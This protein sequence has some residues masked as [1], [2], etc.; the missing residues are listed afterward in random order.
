MNTALTNS[1][2]VENL[3]GDLE[4]YSRLAEIA[5]TIPLIGKSDLL[6]NDGIRVYKSS[7]LRQ[8]S[9]LRPFLF[10]KSVEEI[11]KSTE[12]QKD[13]SGEQE[14]QAAPVET[15]EMLTVAEKKNEATDSSL[16]YP[17]FAV[18]SLT[19]S[20]TS[21]MDA[22]LLMS[23][24]YTPPLLPS[25]LPSLVHHLF[26]PE[27]ISWL[28]HSTARKYLSWRDRQLSAAVTDL[29]SSAD[30]A[31][32]SPLRRA[33]LLRLASEAEQRASVPGQMLIPRRSIS[34]QNSSSL[35]GRSFTSRLSQNINLHPTVLD[36]IPRQDRARWLLE[37]I[38]EEV[39]YGNIGVI[40][41]EDGRH[42]TSRE[43]SQLELNH[44]E[45]NN[46]QNLVHLSRRTGSSHISTSRKHSHRRIREHTELP[47]WA[48]QQ[49][50]GKVMD[51]SDPLG[52]CNAW[53]GWG[54]AIMWGAS[55]GIVVGVVWV[56]VVR[57]WA[58]GWKGVG[59]GLGE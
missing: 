31:E 40:D 52:L 36:G 9:S 29:S 21:E 22:S 3:E 38:H 5:N 47:A 1:F 59:W 54:K 30:S 56:V 15:S 10:G 39:M 19:G 8:T 44:S 13:T 53:E 2:S 34:A 6:T 37:R 48:R 42:V 27:N 14:N 17:P 20:D 45:K 33:R 23:S 4:Q 46:M 32:M 16:V 58:F 18:S 28:R 51:P 41:I 24:N 11:L 7:I 12:T 55:G 49:Y 25:E 26:Q 57:G 43:L 50:H 35:S